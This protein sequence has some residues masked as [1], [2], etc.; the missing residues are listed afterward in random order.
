[1]QQNSPFKRNA[2]TV[3]TSHLSVINR[4]GHKDKAHKQLYSPAII[5]EIN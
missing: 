3:E 4:E 5:G 1:M 2:G